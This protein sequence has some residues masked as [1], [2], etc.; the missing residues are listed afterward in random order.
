MRAAGASTAR[1][2]TPRTS[3]PSPTASDVPCTNAWRLY[4]RVAEGDPPA[5]AGIPLVPHPAPGGQ[6]A[7]YK[8]A[9]NID[10]EFATHCSLIQRLT[11]RVSVQAARR[12]PQ[13]AAG[14]L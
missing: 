3:P 8:L 4:R 9:A 5:A 10:Q 1:S 13:I 7:G 2:S 14:F 6:L 11:A 12:L